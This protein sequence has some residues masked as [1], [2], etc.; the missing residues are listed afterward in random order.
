MSC[1]LIL[2]CIFWQH[3]RDDQDQTRQT[4]KPV[5]DV[6][7][8]ITKQA[9]NLLFLQADDEKQDL[10]LLQETRSSFANIAT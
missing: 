7:I 5:N 8:A 4:S 1:R 10:N 6:T 9:R 2:Q 3:D